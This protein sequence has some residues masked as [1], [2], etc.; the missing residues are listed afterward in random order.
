MFPFIY[1]LSSFYSYFHP[2]IPTFIHPPILSSFHY[3]FHPFIPTFILSSFRFLFIFSYFHAPIHIFFH[4]CFHPFKFS[5]LFFYYFTI[6][7][8]YPSNPTFIEFYHSFIPTLNLSFPNVSFHSH[9]YPF[10][11]SFLFSYL[12]HT[13]LIS[14]SL[15]SLSTLILYFIISTTIFIPIFII[16]ILHLI[17]L[18]HIFVPLYILIILHWFLLLHNYSFLHIYNFTL[19]PAFT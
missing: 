13:I 15:L 17:L 18:L 8:F 7:S 19:I 4:Y 14:L 11:S 3:Y 12:I 9:M 6:L 1:M 16:I 10:V 2:F 5:N